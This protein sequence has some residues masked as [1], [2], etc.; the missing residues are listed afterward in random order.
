LWLVRAQEHAG[1]PRDARA[2]L[3]EHRAIL[4]ALDSRDPS[5][6][7]EA[8]AAHIEASVIKL[9]VKLGLTSDHHVARGAAD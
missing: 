3:A 4:H 2:S 6:A 8:M 7:V 9:G 5:A 1:P